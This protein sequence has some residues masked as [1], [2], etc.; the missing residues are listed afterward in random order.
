MQ[1]KL[2]I[3]WGGINSPV[4]GNNVWVCPNAVLFGGI[5]IG[6]NVTIGAGCIVNKSIPDD[7]TVVG[8]PARIIKKSGIRCNI[9][10]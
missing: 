2:I 5:T 3:L 9:L 1:E 10:L 8:N 6:N 4:I 7:C